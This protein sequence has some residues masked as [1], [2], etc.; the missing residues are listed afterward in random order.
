MQPRD[1]QILRHI[2]EYC[3]DIARCLKETG[4]SHERFLSDT[5]IQHSVAFCILQI[6]ELVARLS[7]EFR[8]RTGGEMN[9]AA[10]KGMRNIVVHDY[11][12]IDREELWITA[13][14]D[15]PVLRQFC[16]TYRE[17]PPDTVEEC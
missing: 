3:E 2:A 14:Q 1:A 13:A 16:E 4:L 17:D 15:V 7:E 8:L 9:W 6:G 11:G 12:S 5:I 10:I